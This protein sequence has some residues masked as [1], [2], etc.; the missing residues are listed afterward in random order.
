[1]F[2]QL[3]NKQIEL[4]RMG[5]IESESVTHLRF[6]VI[7]RARYM[8]SQSPLTG[9]PGNVRI[10]D[11]I[12]ARIATGEPFALLYVDLDHFKAFSD[13]YGFVRGDEALRETGALVRES[14]RRVAGAMFEG[15]NA[16]MT[17]CARLPAP[18]F[19]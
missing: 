8:R 2:D 17:A 12:E 6:R 10:E 15:T 11:E 16:A 18:S 13:R 1:M 7:R 3:G 4:E 5:V 9:L 14:A 19:S